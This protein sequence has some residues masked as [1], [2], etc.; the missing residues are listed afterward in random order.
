M[1][2]NSLLWFPRWSSLSQE[3]TL[4][5]LAD[6]MAQPIE[7]QQHV[8][9]DLPFDCQSLIS[10]QVGRMK[11]CHYRDRTEKMPS[12]PHLIHRFFLSEQAPHCGSTQSDHDF[13]LDDLNLLP[14]IRQASFHFRRS[15]LTVSRCSWRHIRPAFQDIGDIDIRTLVTHRL[16]DFGQEFTG[17]P[18]KR[19][20]P[21]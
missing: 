6:G 9:P 18:N 20:S 15:W 10:Q 13:W 1:V 4:L 7:N 11:R 12:S 8:F 16:N 2:V 21:P 17:S 14:Q 19:F 5:S 3:I